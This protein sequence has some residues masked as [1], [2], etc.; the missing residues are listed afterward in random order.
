MS[1]FFGDGGEEVGAHHRLQT[2]LVCL[3]IRNGQDERLLEPEPECRAN[4]HNMWSP[5][6]QLSGWRLLKHLGEAC[7]SLTFTTT[8]F[9]VSFV[10]VKSELTEGLTWWQT[11]PIGLRTAMIR[12]C[13]STAWPV[14]LQSLIYSLLK[15]LSWSQLAGWLSLHNQFPVFEY[16]SRSDFYHGLWWVFDRSLLWM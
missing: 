11:S 14:S 5:K 1:V 13:I 3:W 16:S 6:N 4:H 7:C 15:K 12:R 9:N 2:V 8:S 10:Y